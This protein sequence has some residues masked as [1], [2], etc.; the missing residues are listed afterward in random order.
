MPAKCGSSPRAKVEMPRSSM[1]SA[2]G[3]PILTA[4]SRSAFQAACGSAA[5]RWTA[6]Q[7]LEAFPAE[8]RMVVAPMASLR[9]SYPIPRSYGYPSISVEY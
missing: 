1:L 7:P 4:R 5:S 2:P 8:I 9:I 3:R 6:R